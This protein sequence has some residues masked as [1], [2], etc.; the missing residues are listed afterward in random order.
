MHL[1]RYFYFRVYKF[2]CNVLLRHIPGKHNIY[3]DMLSRL[4]VERF[5]QAMPTADRAPTP[6]P[7]VVW[8]I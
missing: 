2:E 6:I 7:S 8:S 5:L 4:Q 1:L 3:A